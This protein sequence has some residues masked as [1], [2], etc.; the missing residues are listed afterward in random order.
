VTQP[1]I[2]QH[3]QF[4]EQKPGIVVLLER[5]ARPISRLLRVVKCCLS[6]CDHIRI[7]FGLLQHINQRAVAHPGQ[8]GSQQ[9]FNYVC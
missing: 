7:V 1:K 8:F 2:G 9:P 4:M 3:R 6:G 5:I